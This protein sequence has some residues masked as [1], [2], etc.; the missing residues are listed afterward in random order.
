MRPAQVDGF[1]PMLI[2]ALRRPSTPVEARLGDVYVPVFIVPDLLYYGF[3]KEG[4]SPSVAAGATSAVAVLTVPTDERWVLYALRVQRAT[5][6]NTIDSINVAYDTP[7]RTGPSSTHRLTGTGLAATE[8]SVPNGATA[9]AY[10]ALGILLEPGTTL[11]LTTSGVGVAAS[12]FGGQA[13]V[14]VTKVVRASTP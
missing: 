7:Y 12:T 4:T 5:G 6:D 3:N 8:V 13:L 11:G 14:R 2:R 9:L 10:G 1:W